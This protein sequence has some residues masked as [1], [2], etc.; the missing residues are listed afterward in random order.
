MNGLLAKVYLYQGKYDL[1]K[2]KAEAALEVYNF[3]YNFKDYDFIPGL[4]KFLAWLVFP[5]GLSTTKKRL[6]HKQASNPFVY[7]IACYMSDEHRALY[8]AKDRRLYF[9]LIEDAPFRQ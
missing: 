9:T 6:W 3:L 2:Q 8:T 1:A 7:M 4:P 5:A